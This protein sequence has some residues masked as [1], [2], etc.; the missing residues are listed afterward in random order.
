MS[1]IDINT[2]REEITADVNESKSLLSSLKE[3]LKSVYE[4]AKVYFWTAL[5]YLKYYCSSDYRTIRKNRQ[6]IQHKQQ[7][8]P[9]LPI[10]KRI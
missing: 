4:I 2:L 10:L 9:K 3:K 8:Q 6:E 7:Q 1:E 5:L